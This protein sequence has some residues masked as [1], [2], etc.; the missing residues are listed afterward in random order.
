MIIVWASCKYL[1]AIRLTICLCIDFPP[2]YINERRLLRAAREFADVLQEIRKARRATNEKPFS[3]CHASNEIPNLWMECQT[4]SKWL[5][6]KCWPYL[7]A[8]TAQI[9]LVTFFPA[10]GY[11]M[12]TPFSQFFDALSL[13]WLWFSYVLAIFDLRLRYRVSMANSVPHAMRLFVRHLTLEERL[14]KAELKKI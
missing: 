3:F 2:D 5:S 8:I 7:S 11:Q 10:I 9:N 12:R 6:I 13:K 14:I 1:P 4:F